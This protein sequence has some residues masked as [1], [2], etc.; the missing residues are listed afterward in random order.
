MALPVKGKVSD[1]KETGINL[2]AKATKPNNPI[3]FVFFQV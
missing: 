1:G 3:T 2:P